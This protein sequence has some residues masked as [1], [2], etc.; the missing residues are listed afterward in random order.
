AGHA[1]R[2]I[3]RCCV[4]WTG[5]RILILVYRRVCGAGLAGEA[6]ISRS[7]RIC[8]PRRHCRNDVPV[9]LWTWTFSVEFEYTNVVGAISLGTP[10]ILAHYRHWCRM[11]AGRRTGNAFAT[12]RQTE[13]MADLLRRLRE[14]RTGYCH[15]L[16]SPI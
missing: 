12:A 13:S 11:A 14:L 7:N 1:L 9:H 6:K 3:H 10:R 4:S 8:D 16:L 15:D 5:F 2:V